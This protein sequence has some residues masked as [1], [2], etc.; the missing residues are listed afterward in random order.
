MH[1]GTAGDY[2]KAARRR[3]PRMLFDYLDGGA[4][5]EHTLRR[6]VED[7]AAVELRQRVLV[8]C[9]GLKLSQELFGRRLSMP[10]ILAP[11]GMG[12]FQARRGEAQAMRAADAAGIPL[13]LSTVSVCPIEEVQAAATKAPPWFQLYMI[14]DRG[15]MADL[16]ARAQAKGPVPLLFTV[17]MPAPGLR[18]RDGRSGF[19]AE[20]GFARSWKRFVDGASHPLWVWDVWV[21]GRPHAFGNLAGV[22]D[23]KDGLASYWK[24]IGDNFDPGCTWK[25]LEWLRDHWSGPIL[26]KGVLDPEDADLAAKA[27]MDGVVVSNHGGRQLDGVSSTVAAL[28]GVVDAV[29]GRMKVLVDGGIRSGQDL[30]KVIAL[31]ADA[32]LIGRPWIFALAAEGEAGVLRLLKTMRR[33]LQV[34]MALTGCRD[35][36]AASRSLIA[37]GP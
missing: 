32:G 25:D 19:S 10:L 18:H 36:N 15:R 28:P 20:A 14:K 23:S 35:L 30:L 37:K 29:Q 2:R 13:C 26:L 9:A 3:L 17:D 24:W 16:L 11:I 31:G 4:I 8:D 5:D 21:K 6:N 22:E 7:M 34:A 27:G 1:A 33:E 12:G